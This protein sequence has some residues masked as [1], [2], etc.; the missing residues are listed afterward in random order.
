MP[1]VLQ[2]SNTPR[3][4]NCLFELYHLSV[5]ITDARKGLRVLMIIPI[6]CL[7]CGSID[8]IT[9]SNRLI[10]CEPLEELTTDR[11]V[12][13]QFQFSSLTGR[14][15]LFCVRGCCDFSKKHERHFC[16]R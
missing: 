15:G 4:K 10:C 14:I 2:C 1:K 3:S 12:S 8:P 9:Y 5:H 13:Q 11:P 6:R 7:E 16:L